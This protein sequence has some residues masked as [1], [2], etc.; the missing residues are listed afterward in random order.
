MGNYK[1]LEFEFIER[2]LAL[3][4]Q[5]QTRLNDY[6]FKEQ[7]NHTL[8]INCLLGLIIM[9]KERVG[10]FVPNDRLTQAFR[11]KVGLEQSSINA[12]FLTFRQLIGGLRNS[13]AHFNIK[14]ESFSADFLIDEIVFLDD[15]KS[16]GYEVVRFKADEMLPFARYYA[17]ELLKNMKDH[18]PVGVKAVARKTRH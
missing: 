13:I 11:D 8:L 16:P 10:S 3:I 4:D 17:L 14:V 9:P 1:D 7:Y 2:T 5:Y 15:E 18:R 6:E 12:E